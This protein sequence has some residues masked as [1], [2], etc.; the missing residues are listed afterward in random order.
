MEPAEPPCLFEIAPTTTCPLFDLPDDILYTIFNASVPW[1]YDVDDPSKSFPKDSL[2]TE[3]PPWTLTQVCQRWRALS[4]ADTSLWSNIS[5]RLDHIQDRSRVTITQ[6]AKIFDFMILRSRTAS[7][8]IRIADGYDIQGAWWRTQA[9]NGI[10]LMADR[11]SSV[12]PRVRV[13]HAYCSV[14]FLSALEPQPLPELNSLVLEFED[15]VHPITN[16]ICAFQD[17]P[18]LRS[19]DQTYGVGISILVPYKKLRVCQ[20][21][22]CNFVC[23]NDMSADIEELTLGNSFGEN[24]MTF[25]PLLQT[26]HIGALA[27]SRTS[28]RAPTDRKTELFAFSSLRSITFKETKNPLNF[29][30]STSIVDYFFNNASTPGLSTLKMGCEDTPIASLPD[31]PLETRSSITELSIAYTR[32]SSVEPTK[33]VSFLSG[34]SN[35]QVLYFG[36]PSNQYGEVWRLLGMPNEITILFKLRRLRFPAELL[37]THRGSVL[38]TLRLRSKTHN[39]LVRVEVLRFDLTDKNWEAVRKMGLQDTLESMYP[40]I[41]VV[42]TEGDDALID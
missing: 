6:T 10:H 26:H 15:R 14:H 40:G 31:L 4:L 24:L 1:Y 19:Y 25:Q 16:P 32:S 5:I 36:L 27:E 18:R 42:F 22:W 38:E 20:L 9:G 41:E 30:P 8:R 33:M 2:D 28:A 3:L 21:W 34:L 17:A 12:L 23:I 39:A 35:L 7:L 29:R 13:L 37:S 11:L